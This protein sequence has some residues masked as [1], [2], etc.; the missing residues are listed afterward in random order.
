MAAGAL[1]L[2]TDRCKFFR[3]RRNDGSRYTRPVDCLKRDCPGS[4]MYIPPW[5]TTRIGKLFC[6]S[7]SRAIF[8]SFPFLFPFLFFYLFYFIPFSFFPFLSFY[9]LFYFYFFIFSFHIFGLPYAGALSVLANYGT[10]RGAR[11]R[12]NQRDRPRI[13]PGFKLSG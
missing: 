1:H 11:R 13:Q 5:K 7:F 10:R 8:F 9:C 3:G 12:Y 4:K 6:L 2:P